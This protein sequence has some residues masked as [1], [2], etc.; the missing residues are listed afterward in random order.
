MPR[1]SL[2]KSIHTHHSPVVY[3]LSGTVTA[4]ISFALVALRQPFWPM[5]V[6]NIRHLDLP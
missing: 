1:T 6:P 4:N 5:D 2:S 3:S